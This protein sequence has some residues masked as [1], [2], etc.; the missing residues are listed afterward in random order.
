MK[1]TIKRTAAVL[2]AAAMIGV[3]AFAPVADNV[4]IFSQTSITAEAASV[5]K[6]TGLKSKT[7]SNSKIKLTWKKVKRASGYTVYMRENGKYKKV[8]NCKSNTYTVKKLP[9]ASRKYFKVRAYKTVKG[10]KV[11]GAYSA[12]WNTAT[13]PQAAKGLKVSGTTDSTVTLKWSKIGCTNYRVFQ[14]INGSWKQIATTS[15]TSYTVGGLSEGTSYQFRIRAC[16]QDYRKV[17]HYGKYS[18]A[19][20]ATT[21][22]KPAPQPEPTPTPAPAP[23]PSSGISSYAEVQKLVAE[24]QAY[25]DDKAEY[26]KNNYKRFVKYDENGE[27]K[28]HRDSNGNVI[29]ETCEDMTYA[30][31]CEM[32]HKAVALGFDQQHS[33]YRIVNKISYTDEN[34]YDKWYEWFKKDIDWQMTDEPECNITLYIQDCPNGHFD[35]VYRTPCWAVY[36]LLG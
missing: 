24:L 14:M 18:T 20:T 16:K 27:L 31:F 1:N 2:L 5:G 13:N 6:P 19:V 26:V 11:Y 23:T 33:N 17:N 7:L 32:D 35:N 29:Y 28:Y 4:D 22:V 25:A 36:L 10:K 3:G 34:G 21:T 9:N 12:S 30:E 8:A 15:S